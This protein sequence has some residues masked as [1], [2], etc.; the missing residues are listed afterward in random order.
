MGR[1]NRTLPEPLLVDWKGA[2]ALLSIGKNKFFEL[3]RTRRLPIRQVHIGGCIR[4]PTKDIQEWIEA[5]CPPYWKGG[6]R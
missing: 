3:K 2:C 4:Y 5:G 1:K 6:H